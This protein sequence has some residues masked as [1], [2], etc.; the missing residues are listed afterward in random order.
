MDPNH[1]RLPA[2]LHPENDPIDIVIGLDNIENRG[3]FDTFDD[4]WN[5]K[6]YR[7]QKKG[8][9]INKLHSSE[10]FVRTFALPTMSSSLRN[11][12]GHSDYKYTG[13]GQEISYSEK[14]GSAAD[15]DYPQKSDF[16]PAHF[17]FKG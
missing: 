15:L 4:T 8:H 6:V 5:M 7:E 17:E 16:G 14:T 9:R 11:V 1:A 2:A 10:F 13:A 12:I 3:N